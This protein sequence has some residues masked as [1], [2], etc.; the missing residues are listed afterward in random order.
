MFALLRRNCLGF[1][2]VPCETKLN[3]ATQSS[4]RRRLRYD[5]EALTICLVIAII[6]YVLAGLLSLSMTET[7]WTW[8]IVY[9]AEMWFVSWLVG[10]YMPKTHRRRWFYYL[11]FLVLL[12]LQLLLF[13][14]STGNHF[15]PAFVAAQ[16]S[17][18]TIWG[19][20][21]HQR[22]I[23]RIA[24]LGVLGPLVI[25]IGFFAGTLL[26]SMVVLT[27]ILV[28]ALLC[29]GSLMADKRIR[30]A[31]AEDIKQRPRFGIAEL[32][33]LTA[34][35]IPAILLL[36]SYDLRE[37]IQLPWHLTMSFAVFASL[38][39]ALS[40]AV[41]RQLLSQQLSWIGAF[42]VIVGMGTT[43]LFWPLDYR[44]RFGKWYFD[45][46]QQWVSLGAR[47]RVTYTWQDWVLQQAHEIDRLWLVWAVLFV[48]FL[49]AMIAVFRFDGCKFGKGVRPDVVQ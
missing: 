48:S 14:I 23:V 10:A 36:K 2:N 1:R 33:V 9:V 12:G 47:P 11:W 43:A 35:T 13:F 30:N 15:V 46:T 22:W 26:W 20:L 5:F 6:N 4:I 18:F 49:A 8:A 31:S 44:V 17:F 37:M 19:F 38:L 41:T 3:Q 24:A 27:Q 16:V 45:K 32:M 34:A 40:F 7:Q 39:A 21:G 25:G 28:M 42:T 29:I